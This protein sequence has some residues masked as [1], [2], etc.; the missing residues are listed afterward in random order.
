MVKCLLLVVIYT[1]TT[2]QL[3]SMC[4]YIFIYF[5]RLDN[6]GENAFCAVKLYNTFV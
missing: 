5:Y 6:K 4:K 1:N 3:Q 2:C